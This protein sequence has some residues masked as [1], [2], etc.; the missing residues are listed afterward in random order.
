MRKGTGTAA[1]GDS[2]AELREKGKR[3]LGKRNRYGTFRNL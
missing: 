1:E 2:G 3:K